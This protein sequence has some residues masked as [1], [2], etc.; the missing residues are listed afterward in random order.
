MLLKH[1]D[2][3]ADVGGGPSSPK[4]PLNLELEKSSLR[5]LHNFRL[6]AV[7]QN[8]T[9]TATELPMSERGLHYTKSAPPPPVLIIHPGP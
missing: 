6:T 8:R 1:G 2:R 4:L 7:Y 9:I 5:T 3:S